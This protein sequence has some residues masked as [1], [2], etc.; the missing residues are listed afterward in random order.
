[1]ELSVP[2]DV[3]GE[4]FSL[5]LA[6]GVEV[7]RPSITGDIVPLLYNGCGKICAVR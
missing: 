6:V 3:S 1:M 4:G 7:G 5:L 2:H